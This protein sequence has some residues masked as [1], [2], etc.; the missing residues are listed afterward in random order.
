MPTEHTQIR[1]V[2]RRLARVGCL[3]ALT[4]FSL[5]SS[6]CLLSPFLRAS[7]LHGSKDIPPKY[8]GLSGKS[9]AVVVAADRSI[10]ATYP[11]LVAQLTTTVSQR[12]RDNVG[13]TMWIPPEDVMAFQYQH[14]QWTTWTLKR[15]AEELEVDRLVFIDVQEFRLN[16]PGNQYL[17]KG[18]AGGVVGVVES[19]NDASEAFSFSEHINVRYPTKETGLSPS[20]TSWNDMQVVLA[21]RLVDRASWL[22]YAHEEANV[23]DY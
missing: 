11:M 4:G 1:T 8:T 9:F 21:K 16:E 3:L 22:F 20:Q 13:A 23:I 10:Q 18:A 15:L 2:V 14:P 7:E 5:G 17:W 6:G 19:E 12:L